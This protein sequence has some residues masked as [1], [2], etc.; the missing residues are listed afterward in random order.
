MAIVT[1]REREV[2]RCR[3]ATKRCCTAASSNEVEEAEEADVA[4]PDGVRE[5]KVERIEEGVPE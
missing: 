5:E 4:D 2:T 3:K 1:L